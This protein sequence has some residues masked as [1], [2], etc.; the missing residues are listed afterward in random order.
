MPAPPVKAPAIFPIRA[1]LAIA[2][3][4]LP[5]AA[6]AQDR[7]GA[8]IGGRGAITFLT[9][10]KA[11]YGY[12]LESQSFSGG[13]FVATSRSSGFAAQFELNLA[14]RRF[15]GSYQR[16]PS[17][18]HSW[19]LQVPVLAACEHRHHEGARHDGIRHL[20]PG[21]RL[22]SGGTQG[23]HVHD[24]DF[25]RQPHPLSQRRRGRRR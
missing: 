14:L 17:A 25:G 19:V 6:R 20:R 21:V 1:A 8:M 13:M 22:R 3:L 9:P 23:R 18:A 15:T 7:D 24:T 2:L 5:T 4:C 12:G 10:G 11:V 16:E